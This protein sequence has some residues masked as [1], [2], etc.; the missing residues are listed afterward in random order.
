MKEENVN[1]PMLQG[2]KKGRSDGTIITERRN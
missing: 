1:S 2:S